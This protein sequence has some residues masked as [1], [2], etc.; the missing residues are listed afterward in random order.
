MNRARSLANCAFGL[1]LFAAITSSGCDKSAPSVSSQTPATPEESFRSIVDTIRRGIETSGGALAGGVP[2][3][4]GGLTTIAI[5]NKVVD[6]YIPPTN[7][8]DAP[9][10]KISIESESQIIIQ[11]AP[12][13]DGRA[14]QPAEN[15]DADS[16]GFTVDVSDP[17]TMSQSRSTSRRAARSS[18]PDVPVARPNKTTATYDL[19]HKNGRWELAAEIDREKNLAAYEAFDYALKTQF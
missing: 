15:V 10:A 4:D 11:R 14:E 13:G 5:S 18:S 1:A 7:E 2:H 16:A 8:G 6:E 19:I 17:V 9:R 3:R 12:I